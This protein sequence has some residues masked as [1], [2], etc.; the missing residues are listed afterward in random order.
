MVLNTMKALSGTALLQI[1]LIYS[2]PTKLDTVSVPSS[3]FP[4]DVD[5]I[6]RDIFLENS[7]KKKK[8]TKV[9][10]VFS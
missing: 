9:S 1:Q 10:V 4:L 8:T 5:G 7:L 2:L 6:S 3:A